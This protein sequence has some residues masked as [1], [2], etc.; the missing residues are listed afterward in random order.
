MNAKFS[1]S[2][3]KSRVALSLLVVYLSVLHV[4]WYL[5]VFMDIG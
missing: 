4:W 3:I 2:Q 1:G 5:V